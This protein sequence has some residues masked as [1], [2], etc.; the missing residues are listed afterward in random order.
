MAFTRLQE[1]TRLTPI[2][3][4]QP[5]TVFDTN[6]DISGFKYVWEVYNLDG[7]IAS[8][9]IFPY[10]DNYGVLDVSPILRNYVSGSLMYDCVG[11][12]PTP[13]TLMMYRTLVGYTSDTLTSTPTTQGTN[14]MFP[15]VDDSYSNNFDYQ[16]YLFSNYNN[17]DDKSFL[18][19]TPFDIDVRL[20]DYYTLT[21]T[22]GNFDDV[23]IYHSKW[24]ETALVVYNKS[25]PNTPS[26]WYAIQESTGYNMRPV[27]EF[28]NVD[29]MVPT[30]GIGPVNINNIP[31]IYDEWYEQTNTAPYITED[32]HHYE[33][34]ASD[35]SSRYSPKYTFYMQDEGRYG[36]QQVAF[37]NKNG[38]YSYHTF[39]GKN[40]KYVQAER[41]TF[42]ANTY[43]IDSNSQ[44]TTSKS[45][46]SKTI[47][48]I[49]AY[50]SYTL[51]SDYINQET[52]DFMEELFLSPDVY[53]LIDGEA[54][55]VNVT[56]TDWESK[57]VIN[58]KL[59]N[60]EITLEVARKK[61]INR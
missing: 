19:N 31:S 57:K 35:G 51:I 16:K 24:N 29:W 52:Y 12:N 7:K 55:P 60:F 61:Q 28:M 14:Y 2:F 13:D 6:S 48:N 32:T 25:N 42:N 58:D 39:T 47:H 22:A 38:T 33:I 41:S 53:M 37:L 44:Y 54:I 43:S 36:D 40:R 17:S 3:S 56:D 1:P 4:P 30:I 9:N 26:A 23:D 59:I 8:K 27:S 46:R 11:V 10:P 45:V 21:G 18:T 34:W 5:F 49:T 20:T 15:G 50:D